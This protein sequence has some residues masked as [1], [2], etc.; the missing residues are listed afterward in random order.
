MDKQAAMNELVRQRRA[1]P[2]RGHL[3]FHRYDG[4]SWDFD[5]VVPW[6]KSAFH[7]DAQVMIIGQDWASEQYLRSNDN[8]QMREARAPVRSWMRSSRA[9]G[10]GW[11]PNFSCAS[12]SKS[13]SAQ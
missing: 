9:N 1:E 5:F 8:A 13:K 10:N 12:K 4:G 3:H 2:E 6:S 7:L 11:M